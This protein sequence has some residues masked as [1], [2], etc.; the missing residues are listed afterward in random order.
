MARLTAEN[1]ILKKDNMELRAQIHKRMERAKGKR[2][3]L[4]D[5]H[6]ISMEEVFQAL[7][8]CQKL[9]QKQMKKVKPQRSKRTQNHHSSDEEDEGDTD[10]ELEEEGLEIQD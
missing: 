6:A 2:L 7:A 4:K 9:T 5:Q 1:M 8:E 3:V 10:S